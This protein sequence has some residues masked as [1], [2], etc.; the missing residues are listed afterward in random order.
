MWKLNLL[1]C[2]VHNH[3]WMETKL[4]VISTQLYSLMF[5]WFFP[6]FFFLFDSPS[7]VN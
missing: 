5:S 3:S 7:K 2:L 4:L 6:L 1:V